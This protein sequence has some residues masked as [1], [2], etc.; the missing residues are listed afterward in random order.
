MLIPP[1]RDEDYLQRLG[2]GSLSSIC[3]LSFY[4]HAL[5]MFLLSANYVSNIILGTG[6]LDK[7]IASLHHNRREGGV[8]GGREEG[9]KSMTDSDILF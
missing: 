4:Q 8:N 6:L 9:I 5:K 3:E 1:A 7:I 2:K